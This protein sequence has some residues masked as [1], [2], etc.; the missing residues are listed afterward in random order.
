MGARSGV[1]MAAIE[2]FSAFSNATTEIH[3]VS[4]SIACRSVS[5]RA[6]RADVLSELPL[7]LSLG[8]RHIVDVHVVC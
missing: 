6:R 2:H 3:D 5:R 4:E 1:A 8:E 7:G